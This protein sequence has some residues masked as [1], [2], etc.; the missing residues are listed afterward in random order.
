MGKADELVEIVS[1]NDSDT[2]IIDESITSSQADNLAKA[3]HI[4]VIDRERLILNIFALHTATT[5]AMLQ[6]QLAE[7]RY[8]LPWTKDLLRNSA[9]GE[10]ARSWG[11]GS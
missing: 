10:R 3:T 5:Q 7:L 11:R 6:I 8:E 4:E 2:L 1:G 9:A